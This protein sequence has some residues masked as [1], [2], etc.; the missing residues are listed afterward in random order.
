[1]NK[2]DDKFP[3][4]LEP[5]ELQCRSAGKFELDKMNKIIIPSSLEYL[6]CDRSKE[7]VVP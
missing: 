2:T 6:L 3:S 5:R 7:E 1:M 4:K